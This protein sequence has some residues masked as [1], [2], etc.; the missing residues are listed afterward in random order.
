M[1]YKENLQSEEDYIPEW[2]RE[3]EYEE[4]FLYGCYKHLV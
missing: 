3:I 2:V 1:N 4:E